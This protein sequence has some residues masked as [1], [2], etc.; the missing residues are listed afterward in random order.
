MRISQRLAMM[1]VGRPRPAGSR[2]PPITIPV[3]EFL[4]DRPAYMNPGALIVKNAIPTGDRSYGQILGLSEIS[5]TALD[6]RCQGAFAAIHPN[7]GHTYH[8]AGDASKLY[9][10]V[11][12]AWTDYSGTT[13]NVAAEE[14]WEFARVGDKVVA[15]HIDDAAQAVTIGGT[16]FAD[17]FTSTLKPKARHVAVVRGQLTVGNL[18]EGGTRYPNRVRWANVGDNAD[19]DADVDNLSGFKDLDS[20][21]GGGGY[22]QRIIGREYGTIYQERSIWRMT[23]VGQ[24]DL[25][26]FD[27]LEVNR[28]TIAP[29]SVVPYGR[30]DF[31]LDADGWMLFDGVSSTPIGKEKIDRWFFSTFNTSFTDRIRGAVDPASSTIQWLFPST[32]SSDGTPDTLLIYHWPSKRWSYASIDADMLFQSAS[33]GTTLDGLDAITTDLDSLVYSLDSARWQGGELLLHA[34]NT[35]NQLAG[36]SGSALT[37]QFDTGEREL[38]QGRR[39]LPIK[40]RPIVDGASATVTVQV[41]TRDSLQEAAAFGSAVSV[42]SNG[43]A[44]VR[45]QNLGGR[46]HGGRMNVSGG[47][48]DVQA[49]EV[50]ATPLGWQG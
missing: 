22:I 46:Y 36:F 14:A 26:R 20:S 6:A 33:L 40:A 15:C 34:F 42:D 2:R 21:P 32:A 3:G 11:D 48:N 5:T 16:S 9:G 44:A 27:E 41:S 38:F 23:F 25:Y 18:D 47:F 19:M 37:A 17:Y 45:S 43:D 39:A 12:T 31:Y 24:P 4:P 1:G 30:W 49:I 28:G 10:L 50:E 35:S 13:Y 29:G 7:T 8:Y